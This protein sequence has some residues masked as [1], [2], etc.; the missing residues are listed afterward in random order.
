MARL[1]DLRKFGILELLHIA[2]GRICWREFA[3][4]PPHEQDRQLDVF[5]CCGHPARRCLKIHA[6]QEFRI[7]IFLRVCTL[8]ILAQGFADLVRC[9]GVYFGWR[10]DENQSGSKMPTILAN[11]RSCYPATERGR[12]N[13]GS[14]RQLCQ[15]T[16]QVL[17]ECVE[18]VPGILR[19]FTGP[20]STQVEID[21]L[22]TSR[23][24]RR[25]HIAPDLPCLAT[26]MKQENGRVVGRA[27]DFSAKRNA[28][29]A[30]KF[31]F[32]HRPFLPR[33][34]YDSLVSH[35]TIMAVRRA[36]NRRAISGSPARIASQ[37]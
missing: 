6:L 5:G 21:D 22:P 34:S 24:Q 20:V 9:G 29:K 2:P 10:I 32:G 1:P 27:A 31:L 35:S 33:S 11:R 25:C 17:N 18:I 12:N 15:H 4:R 36:I 28:T 23:N 16:F 37:S 13:N 3:Q 7:P 14:R 30:L 26:A 19:P 8:G